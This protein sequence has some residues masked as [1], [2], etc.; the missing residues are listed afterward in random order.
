MLP[1]FIDI[2]ASGLGNTSFPIEVAWNDSEGVITNH[3]VRPESDW[4]SWDPEAERLHGIKRDELE[5]VGISTADLCGLI[6]NSLS[7][8][9]AYSDAPELERFWLN[10]LFRAGEGTDCPILVLG[11][12]K[13][14]EIRA[15]C[16]KRGEYDRLKQQAVDEVGIIH[17]ADADVTILMK[18]FEQAK[19]QNQTRSKQGVDLNT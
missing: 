12:S 7:G 2:E 19:A 15:I 3:L 1:T 9:T 18:V 11:V 5:R 17:R 16:Y 4:T 8:T 13:V 6:R 10:R 14:P